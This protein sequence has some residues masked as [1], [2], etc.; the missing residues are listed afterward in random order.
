MMAEEAAP[1]SCS[2]ADALRMVSLLST[3]GINET[4]ANVLMHFV[5]AQINAT[6][7]DLRVSGGMLEDSGF[8]TKLDELS[9]QIDLTSA[10]LEMTNAAVNGAF[11]LANTYLV[12][13]MQVRIPVRIYST[14]D[15]TNLYQDHCTIESRFRS[16]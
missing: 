6:N 2:M 11:V 3:S 5:C 1:R 16:R 13:F 12:F 14:P 10:R 8:Q 9:S 7:A 4:A 15:N